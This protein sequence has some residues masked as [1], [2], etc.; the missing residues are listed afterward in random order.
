MKFLTER[1]HSNVH[2]HTPHKWNV[3][4]AH[5]YLHNY[6]NYAI[7]LSLYWLCNAINGNV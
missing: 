7:S 5:R 4:Y 1:C 6:Y 3:E 2:I